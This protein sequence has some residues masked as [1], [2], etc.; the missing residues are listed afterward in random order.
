[1]Y[2]FCVIVK[3]R[4]EEGKIKEILWL[5][6]CVVVFYSNTPD[7]GMFIGYLVL[8]NC[9]DLCNLKGCNS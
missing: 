9:E 6:V 2:D 5:F 8:Q 7:S 1:M 4:K 3:L